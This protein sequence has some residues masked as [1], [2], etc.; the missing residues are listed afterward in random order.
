M[1]KISVIIAVYQVERYLTKCLDSLIKQ[2]FQEFEVLLI[3]DGST[4][5]SG[6]ICDDYAQKDSRFKVFHKKNEGIGTTRQYGLEMAVGEYVIHVDP[7]D[8]VEPTM[9]EELYATAKRECADLVVCDYFKDVDEKTSCYMKQEPNLVEKNGYFIGLLGSLYG[10]CWNKLV[11]RACFS[12]FGISFVKGMNLWEDKLLNLKLAEQPIKVAYLPKAFY[13]YISRK[14]SAIRTHS[15]ENISSMIRCVD[16]LEEKKNLFPNEYLITLKKII[17]REAFRIK[18]IKSKEFSCIYP[19][20]DDCF[21]SFR[22][23]DI[24]RSLNFYIFLAIKGFF[25]F[26]HSMYFFKM[27]LSTILRTPWQR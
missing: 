25:S 11:R 21:S 20:I 7:D 27:K 22:V 3:D 18:K 8:W 10:A 1:I 6:K 4:D 19:E 12:E 23:S 24:G 17:K 15:K 5:F 2:N 14:N 13:H 16:W 26:S 9:L